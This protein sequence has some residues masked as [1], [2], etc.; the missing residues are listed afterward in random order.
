MI[1]IA[2]SMLAGCVATHPAVSW[3]KT[4]GIGQTEFDRIG[5]QCAYEAEKAVAAADPQTATS[6]SRH[7]IYDMCLDLKGATFVGVVK[8][9]RAQLHR[10]RDVC[11]DEATAATAKQP[12]SRARDELKEDLEIAC[13]RSRGVQFEPRPLG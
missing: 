10:I 12:P 13:M 7:R 6:Y 2:T 3:Y 11:R 8:M 4:P 9:P 1:L 5:K